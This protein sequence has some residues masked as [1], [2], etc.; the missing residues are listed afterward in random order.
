MKALDTMQTW[1]LEPKM[2]D[3][4]KREHRTYIGGKPSIPSETAI[5][6][7]RLCASEQTFYF[8]IAFPPD[9]FWN[10]LTLACFA[11]TSCAD[12]T[13]L[14]PEMLKVKLKGANIPEGFLG[15]Y[16]TNFSFQVFPTSESTLRDDYIEKISFK[17]LMMV[18][19]ISEPTED[20]I[21][22][23]GEPD[24]LMEDESPSTY[25]NTAKMTFLL[26]IP[27][28][29]KFEINNN[30]P[31]QAELDLSGKPVPSDNKYYELFIGNAV[32]LFGTEPLDIG[33]LVY[34]LTQVD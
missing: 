28:G 11:C 7:C 15:H 17:P 8:Q 16:Q 32:Y 3:L 6:K 1:I 29:Y 9:H 4:Q 34:A 23:G 27:Q 13:H 2:A 26:Q 18:S 31:G 21:Q 24:W 25:N 19:N 12:E 14:I 5:P 22:I 30:A 33:H 20:A 10:G